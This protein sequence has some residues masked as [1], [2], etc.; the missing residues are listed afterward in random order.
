[1][2]VIIYTEAMIADINIRML[3]LIRSETMPFCGG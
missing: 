1:M 2:H 3:V